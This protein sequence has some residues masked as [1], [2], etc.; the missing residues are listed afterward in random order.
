MSQKLKIAT[1]NVRGVGDISKL[2]Y[3]CEFVKEYQIDILCM[4]ETH[5]N[6]VQQAS[7]IEKVFKKY[8]IISII[9]I[10]LTTRIKT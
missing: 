7:M 2:M 8:M 3:V 5:V 10:S 6:E 1:L 4:Q 9:V